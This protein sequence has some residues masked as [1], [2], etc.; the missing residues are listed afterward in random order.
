MLAQT[1]ERTTSATFSQFYK[2][3]NKE[4]TRKFKPLTLQEQRQECNEEHQEDGDD[5]AANPVEYGDQIVASSLS[6][7]QLSGIGILA[8]QQLLIER[9]Q[10]DD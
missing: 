7:D 5:A 9:S 10:E 4:Q 6:S 2:V 1:D 8:D 3:V